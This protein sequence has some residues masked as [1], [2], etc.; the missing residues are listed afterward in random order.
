M[1]SLLRSFGRGCREPAWVDG[2]GLILAAGSLGSTENPVA[3]AKIATSGSAGFALKALRKMQRDSIRDS[4]MPWFGQA[5][6][7][8]D[9]TLYLGRSFAAIAERA[10]EAMIAGRAGR[11]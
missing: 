5:Y 7:G 9:G 1:A 6:D 3:L 4:I 10:V 8:G 2:R 11:A